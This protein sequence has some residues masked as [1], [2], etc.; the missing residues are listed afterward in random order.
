MGLFDRLVRF[1][2]PLVPRFVVARVARRYIAGPALD[3]ALDTVRELNREGAMAT[4]DY[5][6]EETRD[7]RQVERAVVEYE[8]A[9]ARLHREGLDC[10]VSAKPTLFGL[11]LDRE[12]CLSSLTRVATAAAAAGSFL[13]L[14]MEDHSTT[15]ATL[16]LHRALRERGL[17]VGIVLQAMLRRTLPDLAALRAERPNVRLCK[18]IYRE[19]RLHAWQDPEAVRE[20]FAHALERLLRAGSYVG[21]ATHDERLVL[22]GM[23]LVDRLGLGRDQY[24][25]QMLLGVEPALRQIILGAGHRLRVYVPYGTDWYGYSLRRLREN[26]SIARHVLRAFF[27]GDQ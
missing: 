5:L 12:L 21:I 13:R 11:R 10:N 27:R 25:F 9:I 18:G 14:D 26:P 15:D 22:A 24:E 3:D 2:L 1:S 7:P 6:G 8:E 23:E 17:P 20:A 16:A 4:V 19:P